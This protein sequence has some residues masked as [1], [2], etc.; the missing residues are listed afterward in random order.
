MMNNASLTITIMLNIASMA[1]MLSL[2]RAILL[3]KPPVKTPGVAA[4]SLNYCLA[5]SMLSFFANS[6]P[7]A[8]SV[9]YHQ[10]SATFV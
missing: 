6:Q 4:G 10:T 8:V 9:A 5:A 3:N 2:H 1:L 7:A